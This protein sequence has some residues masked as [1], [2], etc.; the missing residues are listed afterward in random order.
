MCSYRAAETGSRTP[1]LGVRKPGGWR[2]YRCVVS[3]VS[4]EL[5]AQLHP[6]LPPKIH[7]LPKCQILS[8]HGTL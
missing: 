4:V 6:V 3:A 7:K 2:L 1:E 8:M 5:D